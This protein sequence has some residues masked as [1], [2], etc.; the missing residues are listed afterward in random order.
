MAKDQSLDIAVLRQTVTDLVG[1]V[2]LLADAIAQIG[3]L[4]G[5]PKTGGNPGL[6]E[7]IRLHLTELQTRAQELGAD[8][9]FGLLAQAHGSI[10]NVPHLAR[11]VRR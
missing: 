10:R 6:G 7:H 1:T 2:A 3:V 8:N 4:D 9:A 11:F 5:D